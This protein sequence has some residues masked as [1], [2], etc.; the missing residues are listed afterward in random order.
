MVRDYYRFIVCEDNL[1]LRDRLIWFCFG[2]IHRLKTACNF[3]R[4]EDLDVEERFNLACEYCFE[5]EVQMLWRNMSTDDLSYAVRR[6]ARTRSRGF[7][8]YVEIFH[9]TGKKY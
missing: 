5:D 1:Y 6:L 4:D 2:V 7:I 3:I 8:H 9:E